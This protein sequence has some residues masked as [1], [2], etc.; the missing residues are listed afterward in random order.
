MKIKYVMLGVLFIGLV[1]GSIL[2]FRANNY[3]FQITTSQYQL[4]YPLKLLQYNYNVGI[5][6]ICFMDYKRP[7]AQKLDVYA[8]IGGVGTLGSPEAMGKYNHSYLVN[9]KQIKGKIPTYQYLLQRDPPKGTGLSQMYTESHVY[10]VMNATL[11]YDIWFRTDYV[12]EDDL[13][14]IAQTFKPINF[15]KDFT[16]VSKTGG[17]Q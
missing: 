8:E 11:V 10:L 16:T 13:L 7:E 17:S 2:M 4:A 9:K 12:S 15:S 3:V 5:D 6:T 14:K 1:I